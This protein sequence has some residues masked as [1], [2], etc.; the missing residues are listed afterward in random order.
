MNFSLITCHLSQSVLAYHFQMQY[1]NM[2][3]WLGT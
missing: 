3:D 2:P 1:F